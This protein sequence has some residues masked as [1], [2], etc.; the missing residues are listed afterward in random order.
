VIVDEP[1][2]DETMNY[3]GRLAAPLFRRIA[4][5]AMKYYEVPAQFAGTAVPGRKTR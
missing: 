5:A 3:G 4:E 2:L 1:K